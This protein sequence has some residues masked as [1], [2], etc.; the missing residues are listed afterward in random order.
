MLVSTVFFVVTRKGLEN[1]SRLS[2]G[3]VDVGVGFDI[4]LGF[5]V[6]SVDAV[7]EVLLRRDDAADRSAVCCTKTVTTQ[8]CGSRRTLTSRLVSE[9]RRRGSSRGQPY[10]QRKVKDREKW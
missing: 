4:F 2:V 5:G 8:H 1:L 9:S 10:L 6:A 3:I 7:F